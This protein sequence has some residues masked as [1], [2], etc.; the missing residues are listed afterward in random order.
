MVTCMF[1]ILVHQVRGSWESHSLE[2]QAAFTNTFCI[3]KSQSLV[4][5]NVAHVLT[6]LYQCTCNCF[7]FL[8]AFLCLL[9]LLPDVKMM[10]MFPC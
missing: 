2:S 5:L 9:N 8:F 7:W 6:E 4:Q 1:D 3:R 10:L